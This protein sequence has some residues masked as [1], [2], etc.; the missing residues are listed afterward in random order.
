MSKIK[1]YRLAKEESKPFADNIEEKTLENENFREV[2]STNKHSQLVVM[3]LK[4]KEEIGMETHENDQ[5]FRV[6][7]GK[8]KF[9]INGKTSTAEDGDAVIIPAGAEHNVINVSDTEEAKVYTIYSPPHHPP[10]TIHKTKEDAQK[11]KD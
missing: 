5:F 11:E 6:E 7:Q 3:S 4:P 1:L 2:L 10:G 8:L 9:V